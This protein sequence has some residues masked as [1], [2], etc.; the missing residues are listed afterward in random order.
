[1]GCCSAG[2][3]HHR[4]VA[5]HTFVDLAAATVV[6]VHSG[7]R[8]QSLAQDSHPMAWWARSSGRK[9]AICMGQRRRSWS[10]RSLLPPLLD[11]LAGRHNHVSHSYLWG[12]IWGWCCVCWQAN[13]QLLRKPADASHTMRWIWP[14]KEREVQYRLS[15]AEYLCQLQVGFFQYVQFRAATFDWL[16]WACLQ[17]VHK[18]QP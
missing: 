9:E 17:G 14:V 1:M 5:C 12:P 4:L 7:I 13:L 18:Q 8:P 15:Q 10:S 6:A 16:R 11:R 3:I 2:Y